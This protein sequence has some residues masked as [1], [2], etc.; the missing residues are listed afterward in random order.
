MFCQ[1]QHLLCCSEKQS[2]FD[3]VTGV[4]K[5]VTVSFNFLSRL[6]D[7]L[8]VVDPRYTAPH[9]EHLGFHA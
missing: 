6:R 3:T 1:G 9:A 7:M 4:C 5:C 8:P 2:G